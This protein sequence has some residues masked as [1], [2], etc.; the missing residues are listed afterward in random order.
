MTLNRAAEIL[1]LTTTQLAK[2][3]KVERTSVWRYLTERTRPQSAWVRDEIKRIKRDA[4]ARS[5][6]ILRGRGE[7]V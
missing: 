5:L 4:A 3:L 7:D 1:S 6:A 2:R